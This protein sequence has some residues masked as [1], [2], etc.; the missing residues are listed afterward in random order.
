MSTIVFGA[1]T[2]TGKFYKS[3]HEYKAIFC[4]DDDDIGTINRLHREDLSGLR[5]LV[6]LSGINHLSKIGQTDELDR[7]I[8]SY[9]AEH[10]YFVVNELVKLGCPPLRCVFV[11]S[12]TYRVPQTNTSLYCASKAALAMLVRTMARE[13]APT[14]WI[15]NG[16]APG[17]I[18][19]T[20]MAEMTDKQVCE[21]RDWSKERADSYALRNIP[22]RRFTTRAEVCAGIDWLLAAPD[23]VNGTIVD[24]T[25]GQ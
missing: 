1:H 22:M 25:G 18:A 8:I 16:L 20:R 14:G 10:A 17:K 13:L 21:L 9:N 24:M 19:D 11:I 12:Q 3:F 23:Y 6:Y 7:G 4:T 15:I 5:K 2:S